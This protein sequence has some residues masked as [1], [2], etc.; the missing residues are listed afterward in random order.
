M[1][2]AESPGDR[3]CKP[4]SGILITYKEDND[5]TE[6]PSKPQGLKVGREAWLTTPRP[7]VHFLLWWRRQACIIMFVKSGIHHLQIN[8]YV[9]VIWD[10][11]DFRS[12]FPRLKDL[13]RLWQF[14]DSCL[15][16]NYYAW[17]PVYFESIKE[18]QTVFFSGKGICLHQCAVK[19][20]VEMCSLFN[21][22][23][24]YFHV[25]PWC[26]SLDDPHDGH[27]SAEF[28]WHYEK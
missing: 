26:R 20:W 1:P 23:I 7:L 13:K 9:F 28:K 17:V 4:Q 14:G 24:N 11:E 3:D 16:T 10:L 21:L 27:C 22:W 8:F 18:C 5:N 15:C 6:K 2:K 25:V 12:G 19:H